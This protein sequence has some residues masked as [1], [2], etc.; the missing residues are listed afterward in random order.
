MGSERRRVA[1]TEE[2]EQL[3]LLCVHDEQVGNERIGQ[4][5]PFDEPGRADPAGQTGPPRGS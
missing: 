5:V 1:H 2:W 3:E 4:L